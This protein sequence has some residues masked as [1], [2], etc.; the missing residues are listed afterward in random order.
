MVEVVDGVLQFLKNVLL[1]LAIAGDVAER[2]DGEAAGALADAQRTDLHSQPARR[3]TLGGGDAHFFLQALAFARGL[4]Q[5]IDRLGGIGVADE[6]ALDRPRV[7]RVRSADQIEIGG[8]GV[9]HAPVA[10]GDDDAVE[11]AIDNRL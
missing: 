8:I 4:E 10:V 1:P 7:V 11:G 6:Y 5:P 2:P 3:P 9:D